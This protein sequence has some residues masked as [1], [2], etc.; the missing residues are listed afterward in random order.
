ME[1]TTI[2]LTLLGMMAATALPRILPLLLLSLKPLPKW[3][4]RWLSYVPVAILSALLFPSL[5]IM[6]EQLSFAK[7]NLFL[8][9]A[10]P[11]IL[12]AWKT[13]SFLGAVAV[14]MGTVALLRLFG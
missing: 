10:F 7:D 2:F 13:R 3:L 14:G 4:M 5:L 11:T 1:Q 12:V 6:D 9:A 8:W